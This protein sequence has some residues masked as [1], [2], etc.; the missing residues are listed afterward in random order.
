MIVSGQEAPWTTVSQ[1]NQPET[2]KD[3]RASRPVK[4]SHPNQISKSSLNWKAK[5]SKMIQLTKVNSS[6]NAP[7]KAQ[8]D[9]TKKIVVLSSPDSVGHE[10]NPSYDFLGHREIPNDNLAPKSFLP[11]VS[12]PSLVPIAKINVSETHIEVVH[13]MGEKRLYNGEDASPQSTRNLSF[14][15]NSL[16]NICKDVEPIRPGACEEAPSNRPVPREAQTI[17]L[18]SREPIRPGACEEAPSNRSV[19]REAQTTDLP[20]REVR[21][22]PKISPP[23]PAKGLLLQIPSSTAIRPV[24]LERESGITDSVSLANLGKSDGGNVLSSPMVPKLDKAGDGQPAIF[25]QQPGDRHAD[26]I[27]QK[28]RM[29]NGVSSSG[30]PDA[31]ECSGTTSN[32][33]DH[34]FQP[35]TNN[36]QLSCRL[37]PTHSRREPSKGGIAVRNDLSSSNRRMHHH[38]ARARHRDLEVKLF[39]Y[40]SLVYDTRTASELFIC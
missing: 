5:E 11:I 33:G 40:L 12:E 3:S 32:Q 22:S 39:T 21:E 28:Q 15:E 16:E 13:E 6:A 4:P 26:D 36:G 27:S 24:P 25:N 8:N 31:T 19:P 20:S 2:R 23:H 37:V 7:Q 18:P 34:Q 17:D 38:L 10:T 9:K 14:P 1:K 29:G 35:T 30:N